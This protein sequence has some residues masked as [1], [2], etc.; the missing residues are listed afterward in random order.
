MV[1]IMSS[2]VHETVESVL[3]S[4]ARNGLSLMEALSSALVCAVSYI[5][6]SVPC[7]CAVASAVATWMVR[8]GSC[9]MLS[10]SASARTKNK[11]P[12]A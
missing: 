7:A 4:A 1:L 8:Y 12:D 5:G 3:A 2:C 11:T 9:R 10:S 6:P